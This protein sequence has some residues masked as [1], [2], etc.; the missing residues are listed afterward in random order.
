MAPEGPG[1]VIWMRPERAAAGRPAQRSREEITTV[2]IAIADREG[3]DA[4]SMRR[5]AAEP[6]DRCGLA[7]PLRRNSRGPARPDD[8]LRRRGVRLRR[9]DR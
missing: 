5:V 3:L 1:D 2:A 6:R 7:V 4:V 8:R 9:A